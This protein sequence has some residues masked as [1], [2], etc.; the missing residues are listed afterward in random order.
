M[1]P[2]GKGRALARSL[3]R[4][5]RSAHRCLHRASSSARAGSASAAAAGQESPAGILLRGPPGRSLPRRQAS[6]GGGSERPGAPPMGPCRLPARPAPLA[7]CCRFAPRPHLYRYWPLA[8]DPPSE[9]T[10]PLHI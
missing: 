3:L 5:Q 7:S 2:L 4:L 10:S 6:T 9:M 1:E 8:P